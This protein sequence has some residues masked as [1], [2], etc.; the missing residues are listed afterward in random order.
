MSYRRII[1]PNINTVIMSLAV[2]TYE[3]QCHQILQKYFILQ[4]HPYLLIFCF[5]GEERGCLFVLKILHFMMTHWCNACNSTKH[6]FC[7]LTIHVFW[8]LF[9]ED[10]MSFLWVTTALAL[11]TRLAVCIKV[12][13]P[14]HLHDNK[15]WHPST[16]VCVCK[17]DGDGP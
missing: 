4:G 13:R 5:G 2:D 12:Y 6:K 3:H 9:E 10:L 16:N 17:W 8:K 14:V 7:M 1:S 11:H 15:H